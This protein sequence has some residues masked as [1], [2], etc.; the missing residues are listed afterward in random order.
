MD[1]IVWIC[2][3]IMPFTLAGMINTLLEKHENKGFGPVPYC[4]VMGV[5]LV[6]IWIGT[7]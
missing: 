1:I 5:T 6:I 2:L 7:F 4:I 3:L